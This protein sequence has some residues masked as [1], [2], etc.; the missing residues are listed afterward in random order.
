MSQHMV[1]QPPSP[2]PIMFVHPNQLYP[3]QSVNYTIGEGLNGQ[4]F[5]IPVDESLHLEPALSNSSRSSEQTT[6]VTSARMSPPL[7]QQQELPVIQDHQ[8]DRNSTRRSSPPGFYTKRPSVQAKAS[9]KKLWSDRVNVVAQK[10]PPL[11]LVKGNQNLQ[12]NANPVSRKI[13]EKLWK[14][15]ERSG[16]NMDIEASKTRSTL[17]TTIS[18]KDLLPEVFSLRKKKSYVAQMFYA[19]TLKSST[20]FERL[21]TCLKKLKD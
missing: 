4:V 16:Q 15:P 7:Q 18:R 2:L 19:F 14:N 17:F 8:L 9:P 5:P 10:S 3:Q 6:S 12:K 21:N 11:P 1:F 13:P 20:H